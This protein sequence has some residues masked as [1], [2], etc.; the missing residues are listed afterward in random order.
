MNAKL[1]VPGQAS[2]PAQAITSADFLTQQLAE[3]R[4]EREWGTFE[5]VQQSEF[6]GSAAPPAFKI[7]TYDV[8]GTPR[9]DLSRTRYDTTHPNCPKDEKGKPQK[10]KL[11]WKSGVVI[12]H[13]K[14]DSHARWAQADEKW[15]A[16]GEF[17]A[18]ALDHLG[19]AVK[20]IGG[21]RAWHLKHSE[22]LHPDLAAI[23]VGDRVVLVI[24]GDW[25]T[26][27]NVQIGAFMLMHAVRRVGGRPCI[28]NLRPDQKIDDLI[29][30]WRRGGKNVEV[31]LASLE[32]LEEIPNPFVVSATFPLKAAQGFYEARYPNGT[33]VRWRNV[34]YRWHGAGWLPVDEETI[35]AEVYAFVDMNA[36]NPKQGFVTNIMDALH[37]VALL[38]VKDA[39]C[40]RVRSDTCPTDLFACANGLLN[41]RTR[42]LLPHSPEY[43][44]LDW[45]DVT[46]DS[47]AASPAWHAFLEQIYPDDAE[48]RGLLQEWFGYCLTDD[49]SQQKMLM[50]V[51]VKR[52]GK[53]TVARVAQGLVGE[54]SYCSPTLGGLGDTFGL[55]GLLGKKLA[56]VS[57]ARLSSKRDLQ[58]TVE[59]MLRI[60]GEDSI[61]V[62]RKHLPALE[63]RLRTR[64]WIITNLLPG[65]L[66][67]GG[68]FAS[69]FLIL[70]HTKS[71]FG[72]EDPALTSK[73]LHALPGVL[74]WAL[75]GLARLRKRGYFIQPASG[76][77]RLHDLERINSPLKAFVEDMCEI[78]AGLSISKEDLYLAFTG[79]QA[80]NENKLTMDK[81]RFAQALYSATDEK[82]KATK[83]RMEGTRVPAFSGIALRKAGKF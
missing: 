30:Q 66:D 59:N 60:S 8:N 11:P 65:M 82:V 55:Q 46:Y 45:S 38:D 73:L 48:A 25:K 29:A 49:T 23:R 35:R 3:R 71:F 22:Y 15:I 21:C 36:G 47:D 63:V 61:S 14:P 81:E 70:S 69:R 79:W 9:P 31:E 83:K 17:K 44:N 41:V 33:L 76:L 75:E 74:N 62:N 2:A 13:P 12:F 68:A 19:K 53:G 54:E 4:I 24:D 34:F 37:G 1:I 56:V 5:P 80:R 64:L 42:Q 28:L 67:E 26:K 18:I 58:S 57:D 20:G 43:F 7:T 77:D 27:S 51:G 40:W 6:L 50:M 39:P 16:E 78:E 10:Y 52:S 72:H 32:R